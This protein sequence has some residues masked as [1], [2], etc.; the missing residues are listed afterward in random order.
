VAKKQVVISPE[1]THST[2]DFYSDLADPLREFLMHNHFNFYEPNQ[3]GPILP[4]SY[5]QFP[6]GVKL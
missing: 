4:D 2:F 6:E 1:M 3:Q 5:F